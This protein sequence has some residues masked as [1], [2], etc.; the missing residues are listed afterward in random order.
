MKPLDSLAKRD[1]LAAKK[2]DA[3]T[4]RQYA[5]DF[6]AQERFGDAVEFYWKIHD[7]EG[8]SKVKEAVIRQGDVEVLWRIEHRDPA[9]VSRSEWIACGQSAMEMKKYRAA[10]YAFQRAGDEERLAAARNAISP[11]S[12]PPEQPPAPAQR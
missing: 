3:D 8:L 7:R 6:F 11:S 10:V 12:A 9:M 4:V 1:L 5:E 2:F